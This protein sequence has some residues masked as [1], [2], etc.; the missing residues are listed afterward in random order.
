MDNKTP[1]FAHLSMFGAC[2][3]WG[4]MA[5]V[6]K[7]AMLHGIDGI[8]MV[9][10]RVAGGALLFWLTSFF[11]AKESVPVADRLKMILAAIFGLV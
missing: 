9:S 6:G 8:S 7:Y 3:I 4:L 5:P 2:A 10:F 1:L 11:T